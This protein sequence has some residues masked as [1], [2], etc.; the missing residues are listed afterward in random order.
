MI[1]LMSSHLTV[2]A[3]GQVKVIASDVIGKCGKCDW[4]KIFN[5]KPKESL[6]FGASG[7]KTEVIVK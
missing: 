6:R 4:L 5:P 7:L 3:S 1:K 2:G